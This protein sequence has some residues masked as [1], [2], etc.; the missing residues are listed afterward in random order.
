[1]D[2]L[3][4]EVLAETA[5]PSCSMASRSVGWGRRSAGAWDVRVPEERNGHA[6]VGDL[7]LALNGGVTRGGRMG[8]VSVGLIREGRARK[9]AEK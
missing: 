6:A 9:Y 7:T 1:M 2:V 3:S 8:F 4:G 5:N